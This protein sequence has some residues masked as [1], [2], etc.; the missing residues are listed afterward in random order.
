MK[1]ILRV[2]PI[3][4]SI[5][6]FSLHADGDEVR[7]KMDN[8][9]KAYRDL[10]QYLVDESLFENSR[11]TASVGTLLKSLHDN[12]HSVEAL[13]TKYR[14]EPGF[15]ANVEF[16]SEILRDS[17]K[18]FNEGKK[19]YAY[20][21]LRHISKSCT[22]CHTTYNVNLK[23]EDA[24]LKNFT[25]AQKADFY[26]ATRQVE[27]ADAALTAALK[28]PS[29]A[30]LQMEIARKY[31]LLYTRVK[32]DPSEASRKLES[33]LPTLTLGGDEKEEVEGWI[34]SLKQWATELDGSTPSLSSAE[35]LIRKA[36]NI[37]NPLSDEKDAVTLLR[38]TMG[39]HTALQKED[40]SSS[41]RSE[42]L[43]LLGYAY[44]RLPMFFID[45]F[46][47]IYLEQCIEEFPGT[48]DAKRAFRLYKEIV[49]TDYTGSGGTHLP[50]EVTMKLLELRDKA[51]GTL[52]IGKDQ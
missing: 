1:L 49:L 16:L 19:S 34:R 30:Q 48:S 12:F 8:A 21:R 6:G 35:S 32:N 10:Q 44:S 2:V 43:Y 51:Y 14:D 7:K 23:F 28:E 38:A 47:E 20:W 41:E 45:E 52:T 27:K 37:E 31:L 4:I 18:R 5:L 36:M 3:I 26:L 13:D 40:L 9:Y 11:N 50:S 22:S 39:L 29:S 42:A 24:D 15:K 46:P 33:L 25:Q 17:L